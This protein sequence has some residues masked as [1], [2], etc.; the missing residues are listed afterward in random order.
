MRN[1]SP[2]SFD[3]KDDKILVKYK[4]GEVISEQL[5]DTVL[6]ATGRRADTELLGLEKS[7]VDYD[8]TDGK[9]PVNDNEQT[10]VDNIYAIG[11]VAKDRLELTPVAA[12]SGRTVARKLSGQQSVM[13]H[14]L[15][16]TTV[17]TP[18][19]YSCVG[20]S[21]EEA[22]EKYGEDN[23]EAF[24][25]YY[26]PLEF[27]IC[28]KSSENCYIKLICMS[29]FPRKILGLHFVGP[30]AGEVMQGFACAIKA[31]LTYDHLI[32]TMGI[33][34]TCAEEIVRLNITKRSG[35]DPKVTGC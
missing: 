22:L 30:N 24:H 19:E 10:N 11:D 8:V 3:K 13:D 16:P 18:L 20:Y 23:I 4:T 14:K 5:Y 9:I 7:G 35:K 1:T 34:P 31:G 12:M 17:F 2:L 15:V 29:D 26:R 25:A 32:S 33:H 27:N 21:E 28:D 6:L